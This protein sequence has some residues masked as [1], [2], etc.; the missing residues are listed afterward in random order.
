[1]LVFA[2]E[3]SAIVNESPF[4]AGNIG[5]CER[6]AVILVYGADGSE[7]DMSENGFLQSKA[8]Q[9][10]TKEA[11]FIGADG[12]FQNRSDV[13]FVHHAPTV[14]VTIAV[15]KEGTQIVRNI[16]IVFR[17]KA[18]KLAHLDHRQ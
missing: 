2:A 13:V 5:T 7:S 9:N 15:R 12:F 6:V 3:Y 1:M 11:A 17:S 4:S 10:V 18:E 14:G 16:R 8:V